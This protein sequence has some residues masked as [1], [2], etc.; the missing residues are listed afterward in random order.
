MITLTKSMATVNPTCA[1]QVRIFSL[2]DAY[3]QTDLAYFWEQKDEKGTTTALISKMDGALTICL[4]DSAQM[5]ELVE[6]IRVIGA[7]TVLSNLPLPLKNEHRLN[8]FICYGAAGDMWP[9]TADYKEVYRIMSTR[10]DMPPYDGWYVD[11]S[12]RV[13]HSAACLIHNDGAAMC[14]FPAD[15]SLLI[16]GLSSLPQCKGQGKAA[17]LLKQA[18]NTLPQENFF[19]LAEESL[20][21]YYVNQG[22][23]H[24][25]YHYTYENNGDV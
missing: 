5:D 21:K 11:M 15:N 8:Q 19:L 4:T 3:G 22:F 13:R 17:E 6:F 20:Y 9:T 23:A 25:G 7:S 12:H 24:S 16:V 10:F 14:G 18:V 2:F 1:A